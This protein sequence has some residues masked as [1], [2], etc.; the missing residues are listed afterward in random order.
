MNV[1]VR[2]RRILYPAVLV[3][4]NSQADARPVSGRCNFDSVFRPLLLF[5]NSWPKMVIILKFDSSPWALFCCVTLG[6]NE[7][8]SIKTSVSCWVFYILNDLC[9]L[10]LRF[11]F[12]FE[13]DILH[14][15]SERIQLY[16]SKIAKRDD[17]NETSTMKIRKYN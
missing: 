16:R 14:K 5:R 1:F 7:V 6:V 9:F 3:P 4:I 12:K 10:F 11:F 8:S 15:I 13:D 17:S 2:T